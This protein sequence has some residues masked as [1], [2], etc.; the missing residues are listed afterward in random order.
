MSSSSD[1][2]HFETGNVN[3][4]STGKHFYREFVEMVVRRSVG[5]AARTFGPQPRVKHSNGLAAAGRGTWV[6]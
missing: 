6:G 1:A 3:P 2:S 5:L 4:F